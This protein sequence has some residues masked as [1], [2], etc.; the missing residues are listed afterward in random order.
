MRVVREKATHAF[1]N[2]EGKPCAAGIS[3]TLACCDVSEIASLATHSWRPK[4]RC[5]DSESQFLAI[6]KFSCTTAQRLIHARQNRLFARIAAADSQG[7]DVPSDDGLRLVG[8][9]GHA[10]ARSIDAASLTT[11]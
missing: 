7:R 11:A 5:A 1:V 10:L 9:R 8:A 2:I 6:K 4:V 3:A